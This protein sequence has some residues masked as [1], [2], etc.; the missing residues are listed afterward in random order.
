MIELVET[1]KGYALDDYESLVMLT[2]TVHDLR[3]KAAGIVSA[4]RGRTLWMVNSTAVGGGV[5]EMLARMVP[6]LDELGLPTRWAVIGS[7]KPEFF[8]LTKRLHNLIHGTGDPNLTGAD[9]ELLES[10]NRRNA[11]ALKTHLK[12]GDIVC[13]HDPQPAPLGAMLSREVDITPIWRFHIGLDRHTPETRAA[14]AFL[15]PYA[16]SYDRTI[17]STKEYIP[18]FMADRSTVIHPAIDPCS[19]KN[20]DLPPHK[21]VGVLCNGGVMLNRHPVVTPPFSAPALRL[22]DGGRFEPTNNDDPIGLLYRPTVVQVSRW[23]RLKGFKQLL[24]AFVHLKERAAAEPDPRHRHRL[25]IAR[26]VLAGPDPSSIQDDPEGQ[27]VLAELTR[28]YDSLSA[29]HRQDVVLLSLPMVSAKE[30]AL[31]VNALQRSATVVVQN[32]IQEGFG[33]TAT[34][35]MWKGVPFVGTHACGLRAQVRDG[36]DG[37]LTK[38]P[39]DP[40]EISHNIDLL[41]RD[42]KRREVMGR[43]AQRR[44]LAHLLIFK[45]LSDWLEMLAGCCRQVTGTPRTPGSRAR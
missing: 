9:R 24:K 37:I 35:A 4:L 14:W 10:V 23:D 27:E 6:L 40:V 20:R 32:S 36:V 16:E 7:D 22:Q 3:E 33:L 30:N 8:L 11:D 34:E 18:D 45:Q 2:A 38:N 26:L 44:V 5:A 43:A 25:E 29:E 42:P 1:R 21:L 17:F 15:K 41:L 12:P 19:H 13:V 31:L 28:L 39:E